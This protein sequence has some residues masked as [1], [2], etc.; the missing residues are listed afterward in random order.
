[1]FRREIW[2]LWSVSAEATSV[3]DAHAEVDIERPD[4]YPVVEG[5]PTAAAPGGGGPIVSLLSTKMKHAKHLQNVR[6][7]N[8]KE[9]IIRPAEGERV[10]P[11]A[12]P[13]TH[14]KS[15]IFIADPGGRAT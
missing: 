6:K 10:A 13:E 5:E 3:F 4:A 11:L 14:R 12:S 8:T 15:R 2:K 7:S 9:E 1:M